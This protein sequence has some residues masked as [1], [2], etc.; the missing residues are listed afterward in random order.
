MAGPLSYD[1]VKNLE[2]NTPVWYVRDNGSIKAGLHGTYAGI[3]A[4][5]TFKH[6]VNPPYK[7]FDN[8][9]EA[10]ACQLKL[11]KRLSLTDTV[12]NDST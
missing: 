9:W 8:Y 6:L 7:V 2:G 12:G 1:E 10:L 3:F 5:T 4:Y 11:N